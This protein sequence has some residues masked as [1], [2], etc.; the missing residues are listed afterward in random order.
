MAQQ[1]SGSATTPLSSTTVRAPFLTPRV[2]S[3]RNAKTLTMADREAQQKL[4]AYGEMSNK[5]QQADRSKL[6]QSNRDG[7]GDVVTLVEWEISLKWNGQECQSYIINCSLQASDSLGYYL[8]IDHE[9]S[10]QRDFL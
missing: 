10:G 8:R 6:R 2:P 9:D 4:N 1:W 3:P 7:T 5:V